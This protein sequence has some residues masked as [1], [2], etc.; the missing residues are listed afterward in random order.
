MDTQT[1]P[2][3]QPAGIHVQMP[4]GK[5]FPIWNMKYYDSNMSERNSQLIQLA[6]EDYFGFS[7]AK[8]SE[9]CR[10]Q[11][12]VFARDIS[13]FLHEKTTKYVQKHIALMYGLGD[14]TA[15]IHSRDKIIGYLTINSIERDMLQNFFKQYGFEL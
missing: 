3:N 9:K 4:A 13:L 5:L 12:I 10:K 7:R 2:N 8:L 1:L 14:H 11:E 6:V 15:V